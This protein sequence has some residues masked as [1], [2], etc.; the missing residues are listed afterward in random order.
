MFVYLFI[1][2]DHSDHYSLQQFFWIIWKY[3]YHVKL[4]QI[5][6]D[7]V[8]EMCRTV[9]SGYVYNLFRQFFCFAFITQGWYTIY[10]VIKSYAARKLTGFVFFFFKAHT[11]LP[12]I[13]Y[14]FIFFEH[15]N[16]I[17]II[18]QFHQYPLPV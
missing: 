4:I 13:K 8:D 2:H 11:Y 18:I 16:E 7:T 9:A 14:I 10:H 17:I 3:I 6:H 15:E 5:K 1:L 12:V